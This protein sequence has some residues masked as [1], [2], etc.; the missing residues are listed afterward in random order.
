MARCDNQESEDHL[1]ARYVNGL[2]LPI[3]DEVEL[4]Q[5]WKLNDAY[6]LAL[7][8]ESKL[9]RR[10]A[11]KFVDI[12]SLYPSKTELSNQNRPKR[13][14]SENNSAANK[15]KPANC[16][17]CGQPGH[18]M[19]ECP[20]RRSDARMGL[21]GEEGTEKQIEEPEPKY[22]EDANYEREEIEPEEGEC[23]VIQRVLAAPKQD[24]DENW[25]RHN[26][27]RTRCK[28]HGNVCSLVNDGGSFENFVS[29][30]MVDKLRLKVVPHP[31]PYAVSWINKD[32]EIKIEKKC[33]VS[34][35]MGKKYY[36]EVWCDVTPMDVGHLLLGRPWQYDRG[37]IHDG[38]RNT[39]KFM[40]GKTEILLLP[41]KDVCEPKPVKKEEGHALLT[42][43]QFE[44]EVKRDRLIYLLIVDGTT[45]STKIPADVKILLEEFNDVAPKELP[46]DLPPL[47]EIQ[48][49]ID[50][51]LGASLPNK[52]HYRMSPKEHEELHRQVVEL[53]NKGYIR[54]S[55][56]PCVV[57]ALLT[58]KKDG[59]WRMCTDSRALNRITIRYRFPIPRI[60]DMFDMLVGAQIFSKIDLIS[61]YHQIRIK[62][63]DEW[64]TAFKTREGLYEWLVMPFGLSNAPSTFMR[65]MNQA[66]HSLLENLLLCISMIFLSTVET[67]LTTLNI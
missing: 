47:R 61:G 59:S 1:I 14:K 41:C 65:V 40:V 25:L 21:V 39:Y 48:H 53:L 50:L 22:D 45:Q 3:R 12:Q 58:P 7:K 23:L 31:R 62:P 49:Q 6:Q 33:L 52:A 30:E 2:R 46:S 34:F 19:N 11:R 36:E 27:F 35:S 13:S 63:E 8:V 51:I 55:L 24:S 44:K 32:N 10:G 15:A 28:S 17:K 56:S 60:D 5:V 42:L 37:A 16:F 9:S 29:Q 57:P 43:S 64:K 66:L 38:R 18:Y 4:Q 67:L 20:K 54:E 26:I